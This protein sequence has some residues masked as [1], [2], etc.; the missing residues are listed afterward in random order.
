MINFLSMKTYY[1]DVKL[2]YCLKIAFVKVIFSSKFVLA[3][4][5]GKYEIDTWYFSPYP[6][7]YGRQSK[8]WICQ[9]CI[10]YM[11]LEKTYR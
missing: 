7:E 9:Y 3:F 2:I 10:K 11:R 8:L 5:S 1:M 4:R 6:E